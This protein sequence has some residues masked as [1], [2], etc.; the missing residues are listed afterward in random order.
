VK[1]GL[2]RVARH[3][4]LPAMPARKL[5]QALAARGQAQVAELV[6]AIG[7]TDRELSSDGLSGSSRR[8]DA[9]VEQACR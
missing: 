1:Q 3:H 7:Q 9:L 2:A 5:E 4:H 6:R 8:I